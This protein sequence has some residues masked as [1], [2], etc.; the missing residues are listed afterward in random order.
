MRLKL[1]ILLTFLLVFSV[2]AGSVKI[3]KV[4]PH[5]LDKDGHNT[6]SPSLFERDRYQALLRLDQTK[7]STIR[8]DV[9]W[10]NTLKNFDDLSITVEMRGTKTNSPTISF[11]EKISSRKSI[12]SHWTKIRIPEES[13]RELEGLEA[14]RVLI[15][16]GDEIL[17]E[18][19]SFMWD[20]TPDPSLIKIE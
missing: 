2:Q 10:R 8:F 1:S 5:Y 6:L 19:R 20:P 11:S 4:L 17:K 12:W 18:E 13:F 9:Q 16:D 15:K 3:F 14:W 7:C